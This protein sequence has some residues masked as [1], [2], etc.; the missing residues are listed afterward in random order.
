LGKGADGKN[1]SVTVTAPDAAKVLDDK[2]V[3]N[4]RIVKQHGVFYAV[5]GVERPVPEPKPVNRAIAL[6]P[7]HKNLAVGV[8]T[9]GNAIEIEAPWWLKC[10]DRRVDALKAKRDRCKKKS[11]RVPILDRDGNPTGRHYWRPSKRWRR[12]NAAYQRAMAKRREQTKTFLATVAQRLCRHY[13]LIGIGDY[14][15]QGGGCTSGMRRAMNNQS[16]IARF[17]ETLAWT[18]LKSGKVDAEFAEH[19]TTRTCADCGHVLT[20]GLDPDVRAWTCPACG[21]SHGRDE[22]AARNGL[23]RLLR[24]RIEKGGATPPVPGSGPVPI[25]GRWTWR[26]RPSG[27]QSRGGRTE[28][29]ILER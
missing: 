19:G 18:A 10:L 16:V 14:T 17:K 20:G 5:F 15:P 1:R 8:D 6:D 12:F 7:N 3:K 4:L 26:V 2:R 21:Q 25:R 28:D 11:L 24:E 22:N 9:E 13:D 27:I 23:Q 29:A